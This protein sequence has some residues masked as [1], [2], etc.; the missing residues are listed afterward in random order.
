M[1]I[2]R[3]GILGDAQGKVGA[4]I[5]QKWK[6]INYVKQYAKPIDRKTTDQML[7][8]TRFT[9]ITS[10]GK[11]NYFQ[12]LKLTFL[13]GTINENLSPW[14][15]FMKVNFAIPNLET[16]KHKLQISQGVLKS[17]PLEY[18]R[19]YSVTGTVTIGWDESISGN[20]SAEDRIILY[21]LFPNS[22]ILTLISPENLRRVDAVYTLQNQT[23][24]IW[25]GAK[26]FCFCQN[27]SG[28]FSVSTGLPL[29]F[30]Q[31]I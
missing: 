8:R 27:S 16:N 21:A 24:G 1:A 5:A 9:F 2:I 11:L 13:S 23:V 15:L 30:T 6:G 14:N 17:A 4:V 12:L 31:M 3:N 28:L 25:T 26:L 10:I 29:T 7:V 19:F 20:A 18:F 22:N